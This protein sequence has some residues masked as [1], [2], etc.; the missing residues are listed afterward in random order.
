[1]EKLENLENLEKKMIRSGWGK[2]EK[3]RYPRPF[4]WD[5]IV[6]AH[7]EII[8]EYKSWFDREVRGKG[9]LE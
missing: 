7:P 6:A 4:V 8:E 1:M 3:G 2:M 9:V 5:W